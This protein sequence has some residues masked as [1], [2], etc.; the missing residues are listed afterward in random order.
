MHELPNSLLSARRVA[1]FLLSLLVLAISCGGDSGATLRVMAASSLTQAFEDLAQA[2]EAEN[3]GVTVILDFGGSQRLRSQ[4]EFGAK[5]DVFASADPIQMDLAAA[6]D[7]AS[8]TAVNFA[9]NTLVVIAVQ[10]GQ[11]SELSDLAT[12]GVRLVLAH[13]GVPAGSYSRQVLQNLAEDTQLALGDRFD[14]D[15]LANLISEEPNVRLVAQKVALGEVDAG[16]VYQ[17]DVPVAQATGEVR[18]IPIPPAANVTAR[19]PIAA[20][21]DGLEPELAQAFVQFVMSEEGQRRLKEHGF[22]AP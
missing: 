14:D 3:P 20:L 18:V 8:G 10:D 9:A 1:I 13:G 7:L 21:R 4:L 15:V 22:G 2:F 17:T 12:P 19:Y 11:V 6:A 5:A 16:I